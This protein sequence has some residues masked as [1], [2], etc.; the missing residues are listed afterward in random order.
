[1][2]SQFKTSLLVEIE[3]KSAKGRFRVVG[4]GGG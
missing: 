2:I 4:G 3:E 1:M